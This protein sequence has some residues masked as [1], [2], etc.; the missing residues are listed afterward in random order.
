MLEGGERV[1]GQACYTADITLPGMLHAR[2]VLSTHAHAT[3]VAVHTTAALAVPGVVAVLTADDLAV[4]FAGVT[5]AHLL[6]AQKRVIFCGQPVAVVVAETEAAAEDG[7]VAVTVDYEALP[8]SIDV[9]AATVPGAPLVWPGGVPKTLN[10]D[11]AAHGT[12]TAEVNRDESGATNVTGEVDVTRGDV[13]QGFHDADLV[14]ETTYRTQIVHQG[15]LEPNASI[16]QPDPVTGGMTLYSSTQ[17][18]FLVRDK[19]SQILNLPVSKV[20][21]V[22]PTVG[23]AFGGKFGI[24]DPLVAAVAWTVKRPVRMVLTRSED[25]LLTTPAPHMVMRIKTGMSKAGALTAIEGEILVDSG[26]HP[27]AL[28]GL[29]AQVFATSYKVPHL[30]VR[31]VGVVTHKPAVGSYRGPGGPQATFALESQIDEMARR[32]GLDPLAVR[33]TNAVDEGDLM[34][35][36]ARYPAIGLKTCLERLAAHPMWTQRQR[37]PDVGCAAQ[38]SVAGSARSCRPARRAQWTETAR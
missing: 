24:I 32:L 25:F 3:I 29:A 4:K 30:R 2:P 21:V 38:G 6:L 7:A 11:D 20:R 31:A 8:A 14:L 37:T 12:V 34:T 33:L 19:V 5:R 35:D 17:A 36:G 26:T 1:R 9:A 22:T 10:P 18:Q 15:Y 16:A 13:V 27:T 28:A 23:G